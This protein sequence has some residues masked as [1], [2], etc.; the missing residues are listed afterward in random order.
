MSLTRKP[1]PAPGVIAIPPFAREFT[2][3][4]LEP[5]YSPGD[6]SSCFTGPAWTF[7]LDR[8]GRTMASHAWSSLPTTYALMM[9]GRDHVQVP[10]GAEYIAVVGWP[11]YTD[12]ELEYLGTRE[13]NVRFNL[14]T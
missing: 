10:N 11:S 5:L 13:V 2:L 12:G 3:T 7:V 6:R 8:A 4:L 9:A 1:D 14:H